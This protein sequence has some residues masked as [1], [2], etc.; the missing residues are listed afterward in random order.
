MTPL[1]ELEERF[2]IEF[3]EEEF[4]TLNGYL[5]S[6]M[7]K[8]PEEG[9]QFEVMVGQYLFKVLHVENKMIQSVGV[10]KTDVVY[11]DNTQNEIS[12]TE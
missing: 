9:E 8:I 6:K 2:Q 1:E 5:I 12:N 7:D 11:D 10:T 3:D 4:D